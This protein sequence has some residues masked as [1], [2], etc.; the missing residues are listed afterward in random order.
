MNLVP[1][2]LTYKQLYDLYGNQQ[3]EDSCDVLDD[4]YV[5]TPHVGLTKIQKVVCKNDHNVVRVEFESGNAFECSTGHLFI[6]DGNPTKAEDATHADLKNGKDVIVEKIPLGAE[7]VYDISIGEPHWYISNPEHPIIHHNT[8]FAISVLKTFLESNPDCVCVYFDTE[9][10]VTKKMLTDRG[11]DANRVIIEEPQTV[12]EFR[13]KALK[14]V[15]AYE[16]MSDPQPLIIILDS[17][18]QLSTAKEM[19]DSTSG[20]DTRDMTRAQLIKATFRTLNLKLAK[21]KVPLICTNHVYEA[22]GQMYA[23]KVMSGGSGTI[24]TSS[25]IAYLSKA[26]ERDGAAGPVVGAIITSTMFKSRMSKENTKVKA[27]LFYDSGLD[28]YYGL[29]PL[30][31]NHGVFEKVGNKVKMPNG[32]T[33]FEKTIYKNPEKFFT[34]DVMALLEEA[35][36]KE[37]SYGTNNGQEGGIEGD[38]LDSEDV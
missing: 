29:V 38:E 19:E 24:Y 5:E 31:L 32:D 11:I 28:K 6:Q 2:K 25:Q 15:E 34:D 16:K 7:T 4:I 23:A 30:G 3:H 37:F 33:A 26:K 20:S 36:K 27:R 17:L 14:L 9:S 13:T 12:Q 10:A 22:V 21:A 1:L 35:A 18:G 8:F